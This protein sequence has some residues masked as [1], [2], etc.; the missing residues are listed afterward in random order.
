MST[1]QRFVKR[2]GGNS[3]IWAEI[4]VEEGFIR[5]R[6]QSSCWTSYLNSG[7]WQTIEHEA[8][9]VVWIKGV[10]FDRSL[11]SSQSLAI[12]PKFHFYIGICA[13][14]CASHFSWSHS[15]VPSTQKDDFFVCSPDSPPTS[16]FFKFFASRI[17]TVSLPAV[18]T[19]RSEKQMSP[20]LFSWNR[21]WARLSRLGVIWNIRLPCRPVEAQYLSTLQSLVRDRSYPEGS[22]PERW[23][24]RLL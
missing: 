15:P 12:L 5:C 4:E 22:A 3:R 11:F 21:V 2:Q 18:G 14:Q 13:T 17:T 16:I 23:T 24:H 1:R 10:P 9:V 7:K 8:L 19:Y 6:K 20:R